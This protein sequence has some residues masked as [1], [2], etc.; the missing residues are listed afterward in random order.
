MAL[1]SLDSR[2]WL[3]QAGARADPDGRLAERVLAGARTGG[4]Q[5]HPVVLLHDGGGYRGATVVAL[6][7]IIEFYQSRGY[8]FVRLDGRT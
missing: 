7:A 3:I 4:K 1:W 6:S 5:Q 8:T 2:D